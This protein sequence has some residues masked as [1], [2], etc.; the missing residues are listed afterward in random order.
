MK[1]WKQYFKGIFL[2]TVPRMR[3]IISGKYD[4]SWVRA[5]IIS[6]VYL[7]HCDEEWVW[8]CLSKK[9]AGFDWRC[10]AWA[11]EKKAAAAVPPVCWL[12]VRLRVKTVATV[13]LL[14]YYERWRKKK[15][16]KDSLQI[17]TNLAPWIIKLVIWIPL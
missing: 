13:T 16:M 1:L 9:S 15:D 3:R 7:E 10:L 4:F 11:R 8:G 17:N 5:Q 6:N 12:R 2:I 14:Q